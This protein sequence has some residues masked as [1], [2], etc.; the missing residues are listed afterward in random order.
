MSAEPLRKVEP[1]APD[2]RVYI[3]PPWAQ[4]SGTPARAKPSDWR[5]R[6]S[7]LAEYPAVTALLFEMKALAMALV[8]VGILWSGLPALYQ[9]KSRLGI[10]LVPGVHGPDVLPFLEHK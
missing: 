9:L 7:A 10:D 4:R 5:E 2:N 6:W 8:L 1:D 3:A